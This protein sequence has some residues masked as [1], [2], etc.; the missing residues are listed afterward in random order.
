MY[1]LKIVKSCTPNTD[2][3]VNGAMRRW[4]PILEV[5]ITITGCFRASLQR[6]I[7]ALWKRM[8]TASRAGVRAGVQGTL[9]ASPEEEKMWQPEHPCTKKMVSHSTSLCDFGLRLR[10]R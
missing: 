7:A 8:R 2:S 10:T 6:E 9:R 3:D 5:N 1:Y 4:Q